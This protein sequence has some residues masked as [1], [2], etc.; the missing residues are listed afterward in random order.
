MEITD[1]TF[2]TKQKFSKLVEQTVH[3]LSLSYM[4]AIVYLGEKHNIEMED[5][6]KYLSPVI[7]EKI[8]YEAK[9]LHF[10][11]KNEDE[12]PFGD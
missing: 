5:I 1:N 10:L 6:K 2:L 3:Q 11:P 12:L 9:K 7:K 4:A 8:E